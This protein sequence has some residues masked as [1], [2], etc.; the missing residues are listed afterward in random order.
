MDYL[1]KVHDSFSLCAFWA[2]NKLISQ[3]NNQFL[4][5]FYSLTRI[6]NF[7]LKVID[8]TLRVV[9]FSFVVFRE[10]KADVNISG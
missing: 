1:S 10:A 4:P 3:G 9:T 2:T 5:F 6:C 8:E 7:V